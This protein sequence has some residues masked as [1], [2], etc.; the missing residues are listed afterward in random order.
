MESFGFETV[1]LGAGLGGFESSWVLDGSKLE[2]ADFAAVDLGGV[3]TP[4]M[5]DSNYDM[6]WSRLDLRL[7]D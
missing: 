7:L 5:V 4:N 2:S 3:L 6:T 1:G